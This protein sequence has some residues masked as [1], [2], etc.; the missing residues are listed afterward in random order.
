MPSI[1]GGLNGA[2]AGRFQDVS[3]WVVVLFHP[4]EYQIG[5]SESFLLL[6]PAP[7]QPLPLGGRPHVISDRSQK[8]N[9]LWIT[10]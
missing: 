10:D 5:T 2:P 4:P 1:T 8:P 6:G 7:H 9:S 3:G